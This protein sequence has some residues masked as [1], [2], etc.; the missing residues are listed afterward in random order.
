MRTLALLQLT[1]LSVLSLALTVF[2]CAPATESGEVAGA[3]PETAESG[4]DHVFGTSDVVDGFEQVDGYAESQVL[5]AEGGALRAGLLVDALEGLD[6]P[7][8]EAEVRGFLPDGTPTEWLKTEITFQEGPH[9]VRRV[10][11][12]AKVTA[13]QFRLPVDQAAN[14]AQLTYAAVVPEETEASGDEQPIAETQ[15][16]LES[17]L[18]GLVNT[19][20]S[21]NAR[22]TKCTAKDSQ[23]TR[24]AIHHTYTPPSSS[25]GYAARLRSIQ[26]YHMDTRG[27]CDIGYHFL[28]T[29]DGQIWEGRPLDYL[30]AHVSNNNTGNIGVS[31]VGCYHPGNCGSISTNNEPTAASVTA[32]QK[33]LAKLASTKNIGLDSSHV[34]G[35]RQHSGASTEC[36]G[37]NLLAHV[38]E[39]LSGAV[40]PTPPP[41]PPPATGGTAHVVGVVWD[42][43]TGS[44]PSVS[45]AKRI[46]SA[47]I[48]VDGGAPVA[49]RVTDAYFEL[50]LPAGSHE[51]AA[52]A[53]GF[54]T[55][56][57]SV[58]APENVSTWASIGLAP[59][60]AAPPSSSFGSFQNSWTCPGT[61]GTYKNAAQKYY[62]TSFGCWVDSA[63]KAHSDAGDNCVPWC[64]SGAAS[65]GRKKQ[66]DALCAGKSGPECERAVNWYTAGADRFGCG[67]KLRVTNPKNG[68]SAVVA[69]LDRGPAC[70]V[71]DKVDHWA[72]D[73]SYPASNYL[74]GEA[75]AVTEK[76]LVTVEEVSDSTP[77]GPVN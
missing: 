21:W 24:M 13:T 67:A 71:E 28:V 55:A 38:P 19:R 15:G 48:S 42:L 33:L 30:G 32:G 35:H 17:G 25:S 69:V 70:W 29:E 61:A 40:S 41:T 51:I 3:A 60:A 16:A 36:P 74:F 31:W 64:L 49:V 63:G 20:A 73:L 9:M 8:I 68:K 22:L 75:K 43:S 1:R 46:T 6:T 39:M 54:V 45:T 66:Y 58:T 52:S 77:V 5:S 14:V 72:L 34:K 23:K 57:K 37:D 56:K 12:A 47:K 2:G 53:T 44:S 4:E 27:W 62:V 50:D 11:F 59:M 18:S 76:G 10:D 7:V 65:Q 26:A